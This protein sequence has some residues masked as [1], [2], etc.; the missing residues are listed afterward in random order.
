M[1]D[2]DDYE[3]DPDLGDDEVARVR[4]ELRGRLDEETFGELDVGEA[5]ALTIQQ[6]QG[7]QTIRTVGQALGLDENKSAWEIVA[8]THEALDLDPEADV[9]GGV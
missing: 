7:R 8:G 6:A 1:V 3:S 9:D 2:P 4:E 5:A